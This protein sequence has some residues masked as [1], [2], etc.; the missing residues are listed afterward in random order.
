MADKETGALTDGGTIGG[1]ESFHA[2]NEDGNS[3]RYEFGDIILSRRDLDLCFITPIANS[4]TIDMRGVRT[5][6]IDATAASAKALATT[7]WLASTR[8]AGFSSGATANKSAGFFGVNSHFWRGNADGR[9]GFDI[10]MA[11]GLE[12]LNA[13]AQTRHFTGLMG[14]VTPNDLEVSS[15][16]NMLG[17]GCDLADTNLQFMVND[18][19]GAATKT[20]L[21]ASFPGKTAGVAYALRLHSEPNGIDISWWVRRLDV[22][23]AEASGSIASNIPANTVFLGPTLYNNNGAGGGTA[24]ET[25]LIGFAGK[26]GF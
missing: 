23:G 15:I 4:T 26:V 11:V 12:S 3:R 6:A 14:D 25:S 7:G 1:R 9:G 16:V 8:R 20:D 19:T 5:Q 17:I 10:E 21:G 24:V 22:L 13:A 2:V 18:G